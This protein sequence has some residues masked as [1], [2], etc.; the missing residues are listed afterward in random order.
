MRSTW[1]MPFCRKPTPRIFLPR[2]ASRTTARCPSTMWKTIRGYYSEG[3]LYAGAG[4]ACPSPG[5]SRQ[6]IRKETHLL[7]QSLLC[8][9]DFLRRGGEFSL[10]AFTGTTTAAKSIVWRCISRLEPGSADTNCTNRTVNEL[11]LQE[12]TVRQP[13]IRF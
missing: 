7:L 9:D 2:N 3:S 12:V 1:A 6:S 11:L 10:G 13:S 4:G 8:A 5:S